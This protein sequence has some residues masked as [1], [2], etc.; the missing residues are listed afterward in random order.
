MNL[1]EYLRQQEIIPMEKAERF[2]KLLEKYDENDVLYDNAINE[3]NL[4]EEEYED[5]FTELEKENFMD[6]IYIIQCPYCDSLGNTYVEKFDIP[7]VEE[8]RYCHH[9]FNYKENF[10]DAYRV[11]FNYVKD[12]DI[13]SELS[14]KITH[15]QDRIFEITEQIKEMEMKRKALQIENIK[16]TTL[17]NELIFDKNESN[18]Y[19][20]T[21]SKYK[22][23][24]VK[25][26]GTLIYM[27]KCTVTCT[28]CNEVYELFEIDDRIIGVCSCCENEIEFNVK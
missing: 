11:F 1:I 22:D 2:I 25:Y 6:P 18:M 4:T 7:D 9:E 8:C 27:K 21:S 28:K 13:L 3:L 14:E 20:K 26:I 16:F 19:S 23:K 5:L 12:V 24:K 15:N 10:I 17:K